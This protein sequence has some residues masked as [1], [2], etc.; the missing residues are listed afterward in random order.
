MATPSRA[1][2]L[3]QEHSV[4]LD[5][6]PHH[7]VC[8]T[9]ARQ[10]PLEKRGT[11]PTHANSFPLVLRA[12]ENRLLFPTATP[13]E[14]NGFWNCRVPGLGPDMEGIRGHIL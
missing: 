3:T 14:V 10:T 12:E 9:Q 2:G 7:N 1:S 6:R 5:S 11:W 13:K 8:N 4:G